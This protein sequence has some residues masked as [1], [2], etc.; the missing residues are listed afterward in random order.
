[1]KTERQADVPG[2]DDSYSPDAVVRF[3]NDMIKLPLHVTVLRMP[4][5]AH[6]IL[7]SEVPDGRQC[8]CPL[9]RVL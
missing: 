9:S 7:V 4:L 2:T 8:R 5:Q 1:M 3:R 6:R